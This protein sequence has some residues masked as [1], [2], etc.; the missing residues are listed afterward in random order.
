MVRHFALSNKVSPFFIIFIFFFFFFFFSRWFL[1]LVA[2]FF[3]SIPFHWVSGLE[4]SLLLFFFFFFFFTLGFWVWLPIPHQN[5]PH[6]CEQ[7]L[8]P[9]FCLTYIKT[10]PPPW[11]LSKIMTVRQKKKK[12][13]ESKT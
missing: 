8:N 4:F 11:G 10:H 12:P 7:P 3:F 2:F 5:Q 1:G 13:T 6:R 9:T